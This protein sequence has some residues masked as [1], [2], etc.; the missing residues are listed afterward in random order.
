M[1]VSNT[2]VAHA[3]A[4]GN[5]AKSGNM[6]TDGSSLYSYTTLIAFNT[7]R[8]LVF[9]T[10]DGWTPTTKKQLC[11]VIHAASHLWVVYSPVF[12]YG[13][14]GLG[15][16]DEKQ[17]FKMTC[18]ALNDTLEGLSK[19]KN[20]KYLASRIDHALDRADDLSDI[21]KH[22]GF[23][24]F[25]YT[26]AVTDRFAGAREYAAKYK[27]QEDVRRE[28]AR[29]R[30]FKRAEARR[31]LDAT[32]FEAWRA[33]SGRC[34]GSYRLDADGGYYLST[35]EDKVVT[36][37]GAECPVEHARKGL[38]FWLSRFDHWT[39]KGSDGTTRAIYKPWQMNG[40]RHQL[41]MFQL[42]RIDM[43]GVAYAG[44]HKF[45][46]PELSRLAFLLGVGR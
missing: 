7:G 34:P 24:P 21:A 9:I 4:H 12:R 14:N 27:A 15:V 26:S 37:G 23:D 1:S 30:E 28:A 36:S 11:S 18:E 43:F 13:S 42:D 44:C 46:V 41:G 25:V 2:N 3:W 32:D 20:S 8:G 35:R 38:V 45:N 33:G 17:A 29:V 10:A 6:R 16:F 31:I 39:E 40:E 19:A 5:E 22:F